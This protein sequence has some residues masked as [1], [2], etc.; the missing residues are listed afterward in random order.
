MNSRHCFLA[1]SCLSCDI[2]SLAVL[3]VFFSLS[4]L[5]LSKTLPP[6]SLCL[7]SL[8]ISLCLCVE[9]KR[10]VSS[11]I[12]W[13]K[14]EDLSFLVCAVNCLLG[15][16]YPAWSPAW[17]PLGTVHKQQLQCV[18]ILMHDLYLDML[19]Y[20]SML[21][22]VQ[23]CCH[24]WFHDSLLHSVPLKWRSMFL[25]MLIIPYTVYIYLLHSPCGC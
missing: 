8:P 3:M 10:A 2:D 19:L 13:G 5:S 17:R 23:H 18:P 21:P 11:L 12:K 16:T 7:S 1:S 6:L 9:N 20:F 22:C 25:T 14:G 4:L 24:Q 15:K